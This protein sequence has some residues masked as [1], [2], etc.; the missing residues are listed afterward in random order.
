MF[1]ALK[2]SDGKHVLESKDLQS[3]DHRSNAL[4]AGLREVAALVGEKPVAYEELCRTS[5]QTRG[6]VGKV[7][8]IA[9]LGVLAENGLLVLTAA[10]D[11][12]LFVYPHDQSTLHR[13]IDD[14]PAPKTGRLRLSRFAM[15]RFDEDGGGARLE[16]P[17]AP[18]H[19]RIL[20]P[21][22]VEAVARAIAGRDL[23]LCPKEGAAEVHLLQTAL[24]KGGFLAP[25]PGDSGQAEELPY[26]EFHELL[27]HS[28]SRMGRHHNPMGA[29]F[30]MVGRYAPEP[31]TKKNV[32]GLRRI[33]LVR[34]DY[35]ALASRDA[36]LT[37]VLE[38]RRSN[39]SHI[40]PPMSLEQLSEFLH[41]ACGVRSSWESE[42]GEFTRR[43]YPSGGA[44]Y[45]LEVYP[46]V[47]RVNGLAP[48]LYHYDP[49]AHQLALLSLEGE[50]HKE[51]LWDAFRS[52]A[53]TCYPDVLIILSSRFKRLTWK[54][55]GMAYATTMK[56]VGVMYA[57]MYLVGTA[58]RL[59]VCALGLGNSDHFAQLSGVDYY[60]ES[61]V[62]E[63]M[64]GSSL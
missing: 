23:D 58:M 1:V 21:D 24:V 51:M 59:A 54:Y 5:E 43:P 7:E 48:G 11:P 17:R 29:T 55:S 3:L 13:L 57:T 26:W 36:S 2:T 50:M 33:P 20:R 35:H 60:E 56:H 4:L 30:K 10:D 28:R 12:Q 9:V 42:L 47:N 22:L 6:A 52:S 14:A 41:R 15:L 39:R 32:N 46:L 49:L 37:S 16:C 25:P 61:S 18:L 63:F 31:A 34:P 27:F 8:L 45:D 62:G 40:G 53:Q 38:T 64:L 44:A 19:L